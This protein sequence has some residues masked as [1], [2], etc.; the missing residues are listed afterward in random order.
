MLIKGLSEIQYANVPID[1]L[2]MILIRV[3]YSSK[4]PSPE[5]LI[6]EIKKNSDLSAAASA[7]EKKNVADTSG[8]EDVHLSSDLSE[9][10]AQ[11]LLN[12]P[13]DL[14]RL[15]QAKK[16]LLLL[17]AV[18]NDMSFKNFVNGHIRIALSEKA[19]RNLIADLR[20]FLAHETGINW[21]IDTDYEPL[22]ETL[23]F[24]ESKELN[25]DKENISE[26]PLVK[27]IL[28]EFNGAKIETIVRK[29]VEEA[30]DEDLDFS[31]D[32]ASFET[33]D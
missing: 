19:D 25:R 16:Q 33:D 1:A 10:H 6:K 5:E 9:N 21:I 20:K 14:A 3:A 31:A 12:N 4:M 28:S 11:I 7:V 30:E 15:L 23:A 24:Q 8:E 26:Y 29:A 32:E 22:G 13:Q 17:F 18:K 27:A 2:E